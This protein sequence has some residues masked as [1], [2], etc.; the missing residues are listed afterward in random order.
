M[1]DH[2]ADF[3]Q[4]IKQFNIHFVDFLKNVFI[5]FKQ[6]FKEVTLFIIACSFFTVM[7]TS[8]LKSIL[9][10]L[11]MRVSGTTYISPINLLDVLLNPGS[12]LLIL[13]FVILITYM[14][15][16]EIAGLMHAFSMSQ[17]GRDTTILSMVF[18]GIRTCRKTTNPRN[19]PIILFIIVLLPLTQVL[20]LSSSTFK[21]VL[22]GFVNQT[23]EY[24]RI[25]SFLYVIVYTILLFGV[26]VYIF[27]IN[28]Y[29][30]QNSNFMK[31][32]NRS[33]RLIK[34]HIL[35]V[36]LTMSLLTLLLNFA[37]NSVSSIVVINL[38]ELLALFQKSTGIVTKSAE[39]GNFIYILRQ[40]LKSFFSPAVNNAALTVL[41]YRYIDEKGLLHAL[42]ADTFKEVKSN[43]KTALHF[44]SALLV[45][46]A[47]ETYHLFNKYSFLGED[48]H[49]PLVCAHRGDNV[50]APEN[51]MPAF[52]L[53]A[54]E[55]LL[56][57][58]L[59]VHQTSDGV[60]ICNHDS[61]ISRVTGAPL[62]IHETTFEE[63]SKHELGE[64]MPGN[65]EHVTL[66]KLVDVLKFAK[67]EGM[68]VQVELKGHRDDV[69][70]EENVLQAIYEADMHDQ[71]MI[72]AQD[73]HRLM[74]IKEL[75]PDILKGYC[76]VIAF[77]R[78]ENIDYTDNVTIEE[79][80]VTPELV[81]RLHKEGKKVFCWT[82]DLEDT[83]QYLVSCD[84]DVIGTDNPML[85]S[86]ALEKVDYSG[87]FMR[88]FHIFMHAIA[89]MD[90]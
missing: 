85:I 67:E 40:L 68:H 58:E 38:R 34:G 76:M 2:L 5:L 73:A 23:I 39:I 15:L 75:D 71:V 33:K 41:F 32:C 62:S 36:I 82:V 45:I 59:D 80:N 79:N 27:A 87:G 89:N 47:F 42:S 84:V 46:I 31:S 74:R 29:V 26:V 7:L 19:W 21:L 22:P 50:N 12:L 61:D 17:V 30:L 64:W 69:N 18:A 13:I 49:M 81:H 14:A 60:I 25:Y 4:Q 65:Y 53:A 11:M 88:A 28:I 24:T 78:I 55:N 56:W 72:I 44:I 9:L 6:N 63:I 37:I 16:F 66:P 1:S 57:I 8:S 52:E 3:K 90:K 86:A 83:I 77:G 54:S 51:T 35:E 10:S 70:F 43:K 20:P 48:V